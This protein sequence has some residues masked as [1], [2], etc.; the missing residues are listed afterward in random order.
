MALR[1]SSAG[2][3]VRK[4]FRI[5]SKVFVQENLSQFQQDLLNMIGLL[6]IISVGLPGIVVELVLGTQLELE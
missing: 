6:P 3:V 2:G 4:S 5:A 1:P